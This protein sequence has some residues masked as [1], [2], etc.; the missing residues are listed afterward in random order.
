MS[1]KAKSEPDELGFNEAME[2]LEEILKSI[3]GEEVDVDQLA[4]GLQR[5]AQLLEVCRSKI[6]KAE[7]EV[8]QIVQRLE[9]EGG[10]AG[11]ATPEE[12]GE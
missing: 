6:R 9:P 2:E 5:A 7:V 4:S 11:D 12:D 10:E 3:E 8:R 1:T